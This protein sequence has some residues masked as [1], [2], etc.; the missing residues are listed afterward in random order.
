M[1]NFTGNY[2]WPIYCSHWIAT[3]VWPTNLLAAG[4]LTEERPQTWS[5]SSNTHFHRPT[6][7][8][9]SITSDKVSILVPDIKLMD[10]GQFIALPDRGIRF[11]FVWLA[12]RK[13]V[14]NYTR[15]VR[16]QLLHIKFPLSSLFYHSKKAC[17]FSCSDIINTRYWLHPDG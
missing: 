15:Y 4:Q 16:L 17:S 10:Q 11:R 1:W 6:V 14:S 8:F 5:I 9:T 2:L 12:Y 7:S 13:P 3:D